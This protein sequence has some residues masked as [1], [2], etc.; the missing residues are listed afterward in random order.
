MSGKRNKPGN[1]VGRGNGRGS[2]ATQFKDGMPSA[3]PF[4][5]PCRPKRHPNAS[6]QDA[7]AEG[8]T[9]IISTRENGVV[10]KRPRAEAMILALLSRF[11]S[12]T[13]RDQIMILRYLGE[14][15]PTALQERERDLAP[16]AVEEFVAKLAKEAELGLLGRGE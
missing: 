13:A 14:I 16:D 1:G 6:L 2:K 5:R 10:R 12:A 11:P 7:V 15:A 3:N 4:G 9:A 8:L